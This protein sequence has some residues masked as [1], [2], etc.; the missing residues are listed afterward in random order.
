MFF[1]CN[2]MAALLAGFLLL[3][4]LHAQ[5]TFLPRQHEDM[6]AKLTVRA[7][8]QTA[9][10]GLGNVVLTLTIMGPPTLDVEEEP[11]LGDAAAAWKEERLT[12]TRTVQ[13]QRAV[14]S[15]VIRLKQVK[16]GIEPVPDV[17]VRFRRQPDSEW[18]E[19][20]WIDVLRHIRDGTELTSPA[21]EEPSWL[22][23]WGFLLILTATA[24]LVLLAWLNKR[25]HAR[26]E[27]LLPPDRWALREIERIETTLMPPHGEAEAYHT[28][29][30]FVVRRYLAE[31]FGLHALQL[32][33]VEF[34]EAMRPF[35]QLSAEQQ[36]LLTEL[37][38]RFDLAKFARAGTSPQEC[39]HTAELA[40]ELVRQTSNG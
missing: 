40:S 11:R 30:S 7:G 1:C 32:T 20:K 25:R 31:R 8:T 28:R 39:Q 15:Q 9:Q 29:I 3:P 26:R 19:E 23:R 38:E 16:S 24:L 2:G 10:R 6:E 37:F 5:F 17:T 18:I 35:S 13:N 14:W 33:T 12:S 22:R 4:Q 21:A 36:A 27:E 34:L